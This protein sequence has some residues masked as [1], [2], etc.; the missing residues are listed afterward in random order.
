MSRSEDDEFTKAEDSIAR[1]DGSVTIDEGFT[2]I[3]C[4]IR[5]LRGRLLAQQQLTRML[6]WC[7][8]IESALFGMFLAVL[9]IWWLL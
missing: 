4:A 1:M 6:L 9:L 3:I 2:L 5:N 8:L 7:V